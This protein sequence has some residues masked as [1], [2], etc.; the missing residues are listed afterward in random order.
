MCIAAMAWEKAAAAEGV[1]VA[2]VVADVPEEGV[3]GGLRLPPLA[4]EEEATPLAT[5][6]AVGVTAAAAAALAEAKGEFLSC[7]TR[8]GAG[9]SGL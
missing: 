8:L 5:A 4:T 3:D 9:L 1:I 2:T 7:S 6:A